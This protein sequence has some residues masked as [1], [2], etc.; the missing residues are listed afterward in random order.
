MIV[1]IKVSIP[2]EQILE[3][4]QENQ[5]RVQGRTYITVPRNWAT[6]YVRPQKSSCK[7]LNRQRDLRRLPIALD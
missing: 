7:V 4:T 5:V 6:K 3:K 1:M 2:I